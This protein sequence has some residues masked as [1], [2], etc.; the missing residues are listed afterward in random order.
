MSDMLKKNWFVVLIAIIFVGFSIFCIYDTN[1]GKLPTKSVAGKDVVASLGN[2]TNITADE[3][4]DKMYEGG[5]DNLVLLKTQAAIFD[6]AIPTTD[7]VKADAENI[8]A[9]LESEASNYGSQYGMDEQEAL[10]TVLSQYGYTVEELDYFCLIQAKLGKMQEDYINNNLADLFTPLVND[11]QGRIVSHILVKM[12]DVDN[13]TAEETK[14]FEEIKTKL[15]DNPT[16]ETFMQ[17]AKDYADYGDSGSAANGGYLGYMD[18]NTSY[19]D[20]FKQAALKTEAGKYT[21]WVKESNS[22]YAGYHFIYVHETDAAKM[23]ENEQYKQSAIEAVQSSGTDIS[24]KYMAE[25][26]ADLKITFTDPEL[27]KQFNEV[28]LG[29]SEEE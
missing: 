25:A 9:Y 16:Y 12:K 24:T 6:E 27:E 21:G 19:V 4:Y 23:L 7:E 20:S 10:Q 13:P 22:S 8:K 17:V 29:Q 1:K 14:I 15:G 3:L 5:G 2:D 28:V 18:K 11:N 26:I